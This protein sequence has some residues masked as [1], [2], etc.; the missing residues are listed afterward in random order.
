[1]AMLHSFTTTTWSDDVKLNWLPALNL[2]KITDKATLTDYFGGALFMF[3]TVTS[4]KLIFLY[5]ICG[6]NARIPLPP[7][8]IVSRCNKKWHPVAAEKWLPRS[9]ICSSQAW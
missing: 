5:H 7:K 6:R 1:M 2:L 9:S 4:F 3:N 8:T